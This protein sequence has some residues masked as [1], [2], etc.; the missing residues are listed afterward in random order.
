MAPHGGQEEEEVPPDHK[1]SRGEDKKA[2]I[3][4]EA[5]VE[6]K[7]NIRETTAATEAEIQD[8]HIVDVTAN[9]KKQQQIK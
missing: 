7:D 4:T 5:E 2:A 6:L 9:P 3:V 8:K 1:G